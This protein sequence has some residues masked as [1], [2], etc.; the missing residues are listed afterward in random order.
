MS[1]LHRNTIVAA[2]GKYMRA[3]QKVFVSAE[4]GKDNETKEAALERVLV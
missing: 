3:D 1:L 2:E 4:G